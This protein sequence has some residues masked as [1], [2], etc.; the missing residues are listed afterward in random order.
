MFIPILYKSDFEKIPPAILF[1]APFRA[2]TFDVKERFGSTLGKST[3]K[4]LRFVYRTLAWVIV[5]D[6]NNYIYVFSGLALSLA[7][8]VFIFRLGIEPCFSKIFLIIFHFV[9]LIIFIPQKI[10]KSSRWSIVHGQRCLR[11]LNGL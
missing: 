4:S 5:A 1:S 11:V 3:K 8:S 2:S 7:M 6:D 9:Y 10:I